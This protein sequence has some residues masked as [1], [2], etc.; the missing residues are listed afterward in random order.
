MTPV[1][2]DAG[3]TRQPGEDTPWLT[4]VILAPPVFD[5]SIIYSL[6]TDLWSTSLTSRQTGLH[7]C[8]DKHCSHDWWESI[9]INSFVSNIYSTTSVSSSGQMRVLQ[10]L[11][12]SVVLNNIGSSLPLTTLKWLVNRG[13]Q[14]VNVLNTSEYLIRKLTDNPYAYPIN[15]PIL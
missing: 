3:G 10:R 13:R 4:Q 2:V 1:W 11:F 15:T 12:I 14:G 5:H 9:T 6:S 8:P 7:L